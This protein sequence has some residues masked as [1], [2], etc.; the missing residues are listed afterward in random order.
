MV[1]PIEPLGRLIH[2]KGYGRLV[3]PRRAKLP[4]MPIGF[5]THGERGNLTAAMERRGWSE[6]RIRKVVGE[7]W[8]RVLGEVWGA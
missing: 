5:A 1:E 8:L 7:N 6:T 3:A 2:D 4:S